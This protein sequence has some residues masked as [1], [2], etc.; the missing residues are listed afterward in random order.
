LIVSRLIIQ[1]TVD[2]QFLAFD[3][4]TR[5]VG[6]TSSLLSALTFG[7]VCDEETAQEMA[8]EYCDRGAFQILDIDHDYRP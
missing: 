8:S 2:F 5:S 3:P 4:R 1:S 7:V 6:W